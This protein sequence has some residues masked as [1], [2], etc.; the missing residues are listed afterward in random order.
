[1]RFILCSITLTYFNN[2]V[3]YDNNLM[4]E[5]GEI[6]EKTQRLKDKDMICVNRSHN[7]KNKVNL[8]NANARFN[9]IS[10]LPF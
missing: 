5:N 2:Y 4:I 10:P 6:N 1:M 9:I 3:Y 8:L 7:K